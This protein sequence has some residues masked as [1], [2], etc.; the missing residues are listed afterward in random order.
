LFVRFIYYKLI[1]MKG[2][3]YG[4]SFFVF[5]LLRACPCFAGSPPYGLRFAR[6]FARFAPPGGSR[7]NLEQARQKAY[8]AT[9]FAMIE[10]YWLMG[11]RIVEQEQQGKQRAEYGQELLKNLSAD[12]GKGFSTRTLREIRQFYLLFP[13]LKDLANAFT[14]L[15]WSHFQRVLKVSDA[16]ARVYYLKDASAQNWSIC[17]LDRN[18]ATP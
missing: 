4:I 15:S 3:A 5:H 14:N 2:H 1:L 18:V 13:D 7:K 16:Q 10:G 6:C 11:K 12:L 9:A 17:T 8:S